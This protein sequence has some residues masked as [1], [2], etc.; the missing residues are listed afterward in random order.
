MH[1]Y[2]VTTKKKKKTREYIAH[3]YVGFTFLVLIKATQYFA[4][5]L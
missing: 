2:V 4:L 5:K 3:V 1:K